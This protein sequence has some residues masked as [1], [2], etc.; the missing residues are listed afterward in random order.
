MP[1]FHAANADSIQRMDQLRAA[2]VDEMRHTTAADAKGNRKMVIGAL[3]VLTPIIPSGRSWPPVAGAMKATTHESF[4]AAQRAPSVCGDRHVGCSGSGYGRL[5]RTW[6]LPTSAGSL[7][8]CSDEIPWMMT[9]CTKWL[10]NIVGYSTSSPS[11]PEAV[12]I[13]EW[14][15]H[16][17]TLRPQRALARGL[18][19]KSRNDGHGQR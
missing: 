17:G 16:R 3:S 18:L 14:S 5:W 11:S 1:E 10:V 15:S 7:S 8:C 9:V 19:G 6:P 2:L 4:V 12:A 13:T